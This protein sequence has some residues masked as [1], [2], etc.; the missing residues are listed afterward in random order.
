M[1]N[2]SKGKEIGD[3]G[4]RSNDIAG[5]ARIAPLVY[6]YAGTNLEITR[7][8]FGSLLKGWPF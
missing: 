3:A 6:C 1:H 5:S 7:R 2:L 8:N 4:S